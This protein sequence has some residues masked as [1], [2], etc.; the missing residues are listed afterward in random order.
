MWPAKPF[1]YVISGS[2][3]AAMCLF[4]TF[5][6]RTSSQLALSTDTLRVSVAYAARQCD[7]RL[8][9]DAA[10]IRLLNFISEGLIKQNLETFAVQPAAAKLIQQSGT[11]LDFKLKPHTFHNGQSL[12]AD[13]VKN[14]YQKLQDIEF[15]SPWLDLA[16][17]IK[18]IEVLDAYTLRITLEKEN[19][20]I[21]SLFSL[22]LTFEEKE[23]CHGLG[24]YQLAN[25]IT[26][27]ILTL[28]SIAKETSQKD[29]ILQVQKNPLTRM[30]SLER[31]DVDILYLD[32]PQD[33]LSYAKKKG[34]NVSTRPSG[35][36]S[37]LGVNFRE[38]SAT[39]D[40]RVR[41]AINLAIPRENIMKH[42]FHGAAEWPSSGLLLPTHL[43]AVQQVLPKQDL[44]KA[45]QLILSVLEESDP[46]AD[47]LKIDFMI[48]SN[49]MSHRVAMV[50][51]D[52]LSK[53]NIDLNITPMQWGALYDRIKKGNFGL[54]YLTWVGPFDADVYNRL[55]H[56][57]AHAPKGLNRSFYQSSKLDYLL[58]QMVINK[59]QGVTR[60]VQRWHQEQ[61]LDIP[62]WRSHHTVIS[63]S[64]VPECHVDV[65]ASYGSLILCLEQ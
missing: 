57:H 22:P 1:W 28:K 43:F 37:Y 46:V 63:S 42:L 34:F 62:L 30:M 23:K 36:Y 54:Y 44:E 50:L 14:Y 20:Y 38:N 40:L 19:P 45:K 39:A 51:K 2:A 33:Y 59:H 47:I 48:S 64:K 21:Y 3:V 18:S 7:G 41:Q 24:S 12:T 49:E 8:A 52:R 13:W 29:L 55:F 60:S 6:A 61:L 32:M 53:I 27:Q 4:G 9:S 16:N 10:S 35:S 31:G 65:E 56:S 25:K 26:D 5:S 11:V 58:D 17:Q 15:A